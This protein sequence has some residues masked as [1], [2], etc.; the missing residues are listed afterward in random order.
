M[1]IAA[2]ARPGRNFTLRSQPR[3]RDALD[4]A[5]A[6]YNAG[7]RFTPVLVLRDLDNLPCA[8]AAVA[9]RLPR[10]H[11]NCLLRI[12]VRSLDAWLMADRQAM[13]SFAKVRVALVPDSPETL[14]R[15]K[16]VL[17]S[18]LRQSKDREMRRVLGV[19][20]GVADW[21]VI[22]AWSA[23]FIRDHWEPERAA[24]V[25]SAPSLTKAMQR[26]RVAAGAG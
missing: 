20:A 26:L 13:A 14:P 11:G 9:A 16:D 8:A 3:G 25:G 24:R 5:L 10:R 18:I 22:G 6:G 7:A 23:E 21:Q 19:D 15:P 17:L 4:R 2:G 12:A 1:I